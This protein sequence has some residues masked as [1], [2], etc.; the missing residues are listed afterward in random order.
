M[1]INSHKDLPFSACSFLFVI[2]PSFFLVLS[3]WPPIHFYCVHTKHK[4]THTHRERERY[5]HVLYMHT[6]VREFF[7][8]C[9]YWRCRRWGCGYYTLFTSIECRLVHLSHFPAQSFALSL[10]D[11]RVF[12]VPRYQIGIVCTKMYT[13]FF[14][15]SSH[16]FSF[17]YSSIFGKDFCP[18]NICRAHIEKAHRYAV[19]LL[20]AIRK[21]WCIRFRKSKVYRI[22][23]IE[24]FGAMRE[25]ALDVL[26]GMYPKY[27]FRSRKKNRLAK[28]MSAKIDSISL[29]LPPRLFFSV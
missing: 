19:V 7:G 29:P 9:S 5:S 22:E 18:F 20:H 16:L 23:S 13:L 26:F 21:F 24:W 2:A 15:N 17:K 25:W 4:N 6:D 27:V 12:F 1:T 10:I 11:C 14:F 28:V 3:F 8:F